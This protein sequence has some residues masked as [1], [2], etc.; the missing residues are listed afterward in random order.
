[1]SERSVFGEITCKGGKPEGTGGKGE[2]WI[3]GWQQ[4]PRATSAGLQGG[5]TGSAL[6]SDPR[7]AANA[8]KIAG[9]RGAGSARAGRGGEGHPASAAPVLALALAPAPPHHPSPAAPQARPSRTA[10]ATDSGGPSGKGTGREKESRR[11]GKEERKDGFK[12]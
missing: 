2:R 9:G 3:Q 1:M 8:P 5:V 6:V 4:V 11:R 7:V 10:P 12:S